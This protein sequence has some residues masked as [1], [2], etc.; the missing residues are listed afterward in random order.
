MRTPHIALLTGA[1]AGLL[2]TG[3]AHADTGSTGT[4]GAPVPTGT[5]AFTD[6][7]LYRSG[8]LTMPCGR[9]PED[10]GSFTATK[11]H[12]TAMLGCLNASWSA[13]LKKAGL[14]FR[15][16]T[17]RF[18]A[19]P[20]SACGSAWHKNGTGRYCSKGQQLVI[21][22]DD[23]AIEYPADPLAL[24]LIAHEYAHHVQNLVGI[25]P[26]AYTKAKS[27]VQSRRLELQADCLGAAFMGGIWASQEYKDKD[28]KDVVDV[29]R[30]SGDEKLNKERSHGTGKNRVAWLQKG[31]AAASPAACN[32]WTAS[33]SRIA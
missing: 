18:M 9:Q 24:H 7:P 23:Y 14:P 31:F 21:L 27:L 30:D 15:K 3:T 6:N 25:R 19:K 26:V 4:A 2:F 16:P 20:G 11:K 1:L 13:Q 22:I 12:L 17:I 32:T 29:Y 8:K 28:W 10:S 33:A 5:K